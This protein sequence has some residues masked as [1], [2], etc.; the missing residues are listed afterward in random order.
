MVSV[1]R[2]RWIPNSSP[3]EETK[4]WEAVG[5]NP[6]TG[7]SVDFYVIT[8]Y[9]SVKLYRLKPENKHEI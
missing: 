6:S 9:F 4:D 3:G 2:K 7:Y 1:F 5:S 8:I